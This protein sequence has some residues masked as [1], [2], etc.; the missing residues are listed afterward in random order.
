MDCQSGR[1]V[2]AMRFISAPA[3]AVGATDTAEAAADHG[4]AS[5]AEAAAGVEARAVG[6]WRERA[7]APARADV[8]RVAVVV[9][10][11]GH[12]VHVVIPH[13]L[14]PVA[15]VLGGVHAGHFVVDLRQ[16][17]VHAG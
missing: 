1:G 2:L 7:D 11:V 13:A 10:D 8:A 15:L 3:E 6:P 5:G 16:A 17:G 14:V 9:I 4:G 12:G